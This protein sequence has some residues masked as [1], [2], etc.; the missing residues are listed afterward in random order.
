M[1]FPHEIKPV[2]T[3]WKHSTERDQFQGK[4]YFRTNK[5]LKPRFICPETDKSIQMW[6]SKMGWWPMPEICLWFKKNDHISKNQRAVCQK[7]KQIS[8]LFVKNT[9][10]N[11]DVVSKT[12][13]HSS[14]C[15]SMGQWPAGATCSLSDSYGFL[16]PVIIS[17]YQSY[18]SVIRPNLG[19]AVMTYPCLLEIRIPFLI[20]L[21]R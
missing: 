16:L 15:G 11:R 20:S 21:S 19:K 9:Y 6:T 14:A 13:G 17:K 18:V 7:Y 8:S 5:A 12:H 4:T 3:C 2:F 1:V 10:E